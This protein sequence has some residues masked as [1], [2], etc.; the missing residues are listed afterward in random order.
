MANRSTLI[1]IN[2][3]LPDSNLIPEE[4]I[5]LGDQPYAVPLFFRLLVSG[6]TRCI[7]SIDYS[8]DEDD[9]DEGFN[10]DPII[11]ATMGDGDIGFNR[12][13]K[14][15]LL[16]RNLA[17]KNNPEIVELFDPVLEHLSSHR[18]QFYVLESYEIDV[19][20]NY[21]RDP[22]MEEWVKMRARQ[23]IKLGQA[24]DHLRGPQFWQQL[25]LMQ[26]I[27]QKPK[28]NPL[29]D[30]TLGDDF[31]NVERENAMLGLAGLFECI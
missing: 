1:G 25:K 3:Y 21:D 11:Y 9:E 15:G 14:L 16:M 7:T 13:K 8:N 28:D 30:L 10:A 12:F 5:Y 23:H 2:G 6:N 24:V 26:I 19:L 22:P 31:D 29:S 17:V 18:C 20:E 27:T 4:K